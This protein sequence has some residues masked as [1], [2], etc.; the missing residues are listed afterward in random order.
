MILPAD[1]LMHVLLHPGAVA[2]VVASKWE[3]RPDGVWRCRDHGATAHAMLSCGMQGAIISSPSE[4]Y[5]SAVNNSI[6]CKQA[7]LQSGENRAIGTE[8]EKSKATTCGSALPSNV[9]V[10]PN[11]CHHAMQLDQGELPLGAARRHS[12]KCGGRSGLVRRDLVCAL[13]TLV[14]E[15]NSSLVLIRILWLHRVWR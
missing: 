13:F 2:Y 5:R 10:S 4:R 15:A 1:C 11:P 12:Q 6:E 7:H 3:H 8:E 9:V 14:S